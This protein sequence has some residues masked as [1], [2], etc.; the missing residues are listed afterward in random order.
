[1]VRLVEEKDLDALSM[2]ESEIAVQ[3]FGEEA[4]T[5]YAHHR[6]RIQKAMEK[7]REGMLVLEEEGE[8]MGWLW[9]S[10]QINSVSMEQYINFRSF[11][12][13]RKENA[14][15]ELSYSEELMQAG[16]EYARSTG[17]SRIVGKTF[18]SNLPMR[19]LYQKFH[20]KP[21]H[22]TMEYHC[23]DQKT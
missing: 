16:M 13:K 15:G 17:A 12:A 2:M 11:Y 9:M 14:K 22:I 6:K 18:V 19:L 3:S 5:E 1:M 8:V 21:T 20:F 4:V 7:S 23:G 10:L